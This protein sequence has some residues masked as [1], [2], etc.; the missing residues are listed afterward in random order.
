MA[1]FVALEDCGVSLNLES[2]VLLPEVF[3]KALMIAWNLGDQPIHF[4][5][6][7]FDMLQHYRPL[8][9]VLRRPTNLG[10]QGY[11]FAGHHEIVIPLLA[12]VICFY[13]GEGTN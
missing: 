5:M 11:T 3:L 13:L 1:I 9:N 4:T 10:G 8:E 7:N 2:A 6:A 12:G